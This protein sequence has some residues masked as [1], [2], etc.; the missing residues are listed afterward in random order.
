MDA[1]FGGALQVLDKTM[2]AVSIGIQ[3]LYYHQGTINQGM[4]SLL[5][6]FAL[7]AKVDSIIQLVV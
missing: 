2:R 3:R 7:T 6:F 1:K 5:L 4:S